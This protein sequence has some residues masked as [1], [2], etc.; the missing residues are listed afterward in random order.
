MGFESKLENRAISKQDIQ[1]SL[2][3]W[4][5][6]AQQANAYKLRQQLKFKAPNQY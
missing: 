1:R 4:F 3:S 6:Y 5:G 2:V